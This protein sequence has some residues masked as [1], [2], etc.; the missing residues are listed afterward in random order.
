[1]KALW[2]KH[3]LLFLGLL[4]LVCLLVLVAGWSA[5]QADPRTD[6]VYIS[7][8]TAVLFGPDGKKYIIAEGS[9]SILVLNEEDQYLRTLSGGQQSQGFYYAQSLAAD[10]EGNLYISDKILG[11]NG[12]DIQSERI[13]VYDKNGG[14]VDYLYELPRESTQ[15]DNRVRIQ[16]LRWRDG[17]LWFVQIEQEGLRLRT[18]DK[19]TGEQTEAGFYPC[20]D[21]WRKVMYAAVSP[22]G[23]VYFTDKYGA[24]YQASEEGSHTLL[25]DPVASGEESSIAS[26]LVCAAD[27]SIYFNDLGKREIRRITPEG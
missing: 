8:P 16:D 13:A 23:T 25:Y 1:M 4:A 6:S 21:A 27:G 3:R 22:E 26:N 18:L 7:D 10:E 11:E 15:G 12:K 2:K 17:K 24:L 19:D 14:F 9:T 20:E 5:L